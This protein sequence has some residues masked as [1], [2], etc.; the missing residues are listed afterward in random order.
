MTHGTYPAFVRLHAAED[1]MGMRNDAAGYGSVAR[2]L[3]WTA[4][5]CV[6]AA[7]LLGTFIDD[8]PKAW[9][10]AVL[11][12][13]MTLGL[14]VAALLLCRLGWRAANAPPPFV[15]TAFEPW[16]GYA[17]RT[18]HIALY[19]LLFAVPVAG[20]VL[21][22]ARGQALPLFGIFQIASPWVRDQ[23][24]ARSAKGVHELL[25]DILLIL[26]AGHAAAALVHHYVLR[27]ATLRRMLPGPLGR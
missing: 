27:D 10:S 19:L 25:A 13:H 4:A 8:L 2:L 24:F 12:A 18:G 3:H 9:G 17:A 16:A 15:T 5:A 20:I 26:A 11:F 23:A 14:S 22:F 1:E 21:E 7:W 6:A